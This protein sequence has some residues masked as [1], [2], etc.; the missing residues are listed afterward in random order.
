MTICKSPHNSSP[1]K[2]SR[3]PKNPR[4]KIFLENERRIHHAIHRAIRSR[5]INLTASKIYQSAGIT[6]PTFYLHCRNSTDAKRRYELR[7]EQD[8][9]GQI[10]LHAKKASVFHCL[11][12]HIVR[13]NQ[14]F[15]SVL[16]G[17]DSYLLRK[18]ILHY[19]TSLVGHNISDPAFI[20]YMYNLEAVIFCW[21]KYDRFSKQKMQDYISKMMRVRPMEF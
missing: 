17:H 19:R 3:G 15:R 14:Y 4:H 1:S 2:L 6:P 21:G 16:I 20:H 7:I 13:H 9:Y 18:I 10:P 11:A 12:V 8:L 5:T